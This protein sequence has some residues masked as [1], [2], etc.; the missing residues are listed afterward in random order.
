MQHEWLQVDREEEKGSDENSQPLSTSPVVL[1]LHRFTP[2]PQWQMINWWSW[3]TE[4]HVELTSYCTA[5]EPSTQL[6]I[7]TMWKC[8][9]CCE[10]FFASRDKTIYFPCGMCYIYWRRNHIEAY[11]F[12]SYQQTNPNLFLICVSYSYKCWMKGHKRTE[13]VQFELCNSC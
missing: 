1:L 9:G 10:G 13:S 8:A 3:V 2:S 6:H 7:H 4:F 11:H 12:S 5:K